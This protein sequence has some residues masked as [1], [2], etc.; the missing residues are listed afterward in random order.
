VKV[1]AIGATTVVNTTTTTDAGA[2]TTEAL[3]KTLFTLAASQDEAERLMYAATHG[4]LTFAL[5][6]DKANLK[7]GPGV[8]STNLFR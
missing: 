3:P 2:Q 8:T 1:I 5:A 7:T 6:S 4:A